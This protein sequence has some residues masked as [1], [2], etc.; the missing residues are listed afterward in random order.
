MTKA[1]ENLNVQV[2]RMKALMNYGLN[3]SKKSTANP[4]EYTKMGGDGKLYGIVREGTKY[5]IKVGKDTKKGALVENFNYIGGFRNRK[6]NEYAGYAMAQKQ[7]DEKMKSIN[8]AVL[9]NQSRIITESWDIDKAGELTA[10]ISNQMKKEIAREK[11][12]MSN[13]S[14]INEGKSSAPFTEKVKDCKE[15]S[16]TS[17]K[18]EDANKEFETVKEPGTCPK[19]HKSMEECTCGD[20]GCTC[21]DKKKKA[22]ESTETPLTSRENPDYMD[23]SNGTEI[24]NSAPFEKSVKSSEEGNDK[25]EMVEEG[26]VLHNSQNQDV[27]KPHTGEIGD[28]KPFDKKVK[29]NESIEDLDNADINDDGEDTDGIDG[30]EEIG[31]EDGIDGTEEIGDE[32]GIDSQEDDTEE[33]DDIASRMDTLED[34]LDQL[35]NA[36][37]DMD[38]D[39]ED[40][41]HGDDSD[42]DDSEEDDDD[43]EEPELGDETD[44]EKD[45]NGIEKPEEE[46]SVYE[47]K[48]YKRAMVKESQK[49]RKK[50]NEALKENDFGKHPAYQKKVME[51]PTNKIGEKEGQYDMNDSSADGEE[52]F[53]TKK[54]N[55]APYQISVQDLTNSIAESI[56]RFFGKNQ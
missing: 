37:R 4:V 7:F 54:G 49:K 2:S 18:A 46:C 39:D 1:N 16:K 12:I 48:A 41:Y 33:D 19:C 55:S 24:G 8:E 43:F 20:K 14:H 11:E 5:Y 45:E 32:D 15:C 44:K 17:G 27:P 6:E 36:V 50:V 53:G 34:K 13:A 31:D 28:G 23:K 38:Y 42:D 3:E 21:G 40:L 30:T 35:L 56:Q 26:E 25:D 51:L 9:G 29:A 10:D 47:T 52:P 22:N